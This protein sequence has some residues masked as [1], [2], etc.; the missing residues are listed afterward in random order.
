MLIV[1]NSWCPP[2]KVAEL[3]KVYLE[4]MKKYPDDRSIAKTI[5][6]NALKAR[7]NGVEVVGIV[8][9]KPGKLEVALNRT[10]NTMIFYNDIVGFEYEIEVRFNVVEAMA[11]VGMKAPEG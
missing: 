11:M 3:G 5:V 1:S 6:Q 8:E 2:G 10:Q 9:P 7:K 4:V